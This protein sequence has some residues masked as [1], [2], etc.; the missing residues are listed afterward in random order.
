MHEPETTNRS[1]SRNRGCIEPGTVQKLCTRTRTRSVRAPGSVSRPV[2]SLRAPDSLFPRGSCA[3]HPI[4]GPRAP[5]RGPLRTGSPVGCVAVSDLEQDWHTWHA[6]RQQDLNTDYGWLSVVAFDWRPASPTVLS[7]LPGD[8]VGGFAQL[9]ALW[10][11]ARR[12]GAA[13][14]AVRHSPA[15]SAG[16]DTTY[17]RLRRLLQETAASWSG[18]YCPALVD[19]TTRPWP[20][21]ADGIQLWHGSASSSMWTGRWWRSRSRGGLGRLRCRGRAVRPSAVRRGAGRGG[22]VPRASGRTRHAAGSRRTR[23]G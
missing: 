18:T 15:R 2:R 5:A 19:A 6:A 12:T 13:G 16:S 23:A 22:S 1:H 4:W 14:R 3:V 9:V 21:R 20:F 10:R 8:L 7:G 17:E 11:S